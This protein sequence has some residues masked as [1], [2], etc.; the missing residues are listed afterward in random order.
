M[1]RGIVA[2][3]GHAARDARDDPLG[4]RYPG[5]ARRAHRRDHPV[6]PDAASRRRR[7]CR[8][9]GRRVRARRRRRRPAGPRSGVYAQYLVTAVSRGEGKKSMSIVKM[10]VA[11]SLAGLLASACG[12]APAAAE[13][14]TAQVTRGAVTQTVA[15]SGSV[16]SAGTVKLNPATN[17][18]V[19]QLLVTVGQQVTAGQPLAKLDTTD[20]QAAV[21]T[22]QNNVAAAQTNYDKAVA[23]VSDAQSNLTTTQQSTANSIA[24]AQAALSR[25]KANYA[26]A[27]GTFTN[28]SSS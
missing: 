14:R 2:P 27:E 9:R 20:L 11:V 4:R 24:N 15:V 25:L 21:T 28:L 6:R 23:G 10:L 22:A 12:A 16:S 13:S 17:A 3:R 19:A 8:L 18:K 7:A 1:R 26:A 5:T